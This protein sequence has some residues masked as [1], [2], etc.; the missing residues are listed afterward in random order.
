[1]ASEQLQACLHSN[2]SCFDCAEPQANYLSS[3][4]GVTLCESCA[5]V[6]QSAGISAVID[7]LEPSY[8]EAHC[9]FLLTYGGNEQFRQFLAG[10]QVKPTAPPEFKYR[11]NAAWVYRDCLL[12]AVEAGRPAFF[13]VIR[14]EDGLLWQL[15]SPQPST[16]HLPVMQAVMDVYGVAEEQGKQVYGE[17][18]EFTKVEG[19]QKVEN[20]A[21]KLLDRVDTWLNSK[22]SESKPA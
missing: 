5:H 9:V 21:I 12:E 19:L 7:L 2:S 3:D 22:K 20:K 1:M 11:I 16:E 13:P 17:L 14:V 15:E 18:N 10:F 4:F 6:H 8:P